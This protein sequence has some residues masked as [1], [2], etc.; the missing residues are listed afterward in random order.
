MEILTRGT[1]L[2]MLY[3]A[4][5][6]AREVQRDDESFPAALERVLDGKAEHELRKESIR[7]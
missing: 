2:T 1:I 4:V 6:E 3:E 7:D 5:Q